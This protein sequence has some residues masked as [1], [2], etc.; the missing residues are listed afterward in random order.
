VNPE[1]SSINAGPPPPA[2]PTDDRRLGPL[3]EGPALTHQL[4]RFPAKLHPP[5]A[6]H[7]LDEFSEPGDRVLDPFCGS[8]TVLVEASVSGRHA[9]GVD[10][11]PLS[12][13]LSNVKVTRTEPSRLRAAG[14][15]LVE[16]LATLRRP[17]DEYLARRFEDI[18][19]DEL[20]R[21]LD[22]LWVP[23][24][25]NLRHWFR[26]YV[27]ADLA[28]IRRA[29]D[30]VGAGPDV[31]DV[32][33]TCFAASLRASSNADPV[34]VSGLEVTAHMRRRHAAGRVIDPFANFTKRLEA[35]IIAVE[36]YARVRDP[37]AFCAAI[38]GDATRMRRRM[39]GRFDAVITSPPYHAAVDY[40]RRHQLE[41]YWL[42]L[43]LS[44]DDRVRL[45]DRYLGRATVP[46]QHRLVRARGELPL[47]A[48]AIEREIRAAS[49]RRADAFIHYC[50]GLRR[51]YQA[52]A[53]QVEP[54]ARVVFVVGDSRWS[55][56]ELPAVAVMSALAQPALHLVDH[57]W[58]AARNRHMSF[59]RHNGADIDR[60]H[61]LVFKRVGRRQ[62]R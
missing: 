20:G 14:E 30:H 24:I 48:A 50:V 39:A 52:I 53:Q 10:V 3:P 43:T 5:L 18:S 35:A 33:A 47:E 28:V 56:G 9:T 31:R 55:D 62:A 45:L 8:G 16:T 7:L 40:Y 37:R 42:G 61:V 13:L 60:E 58:F 49:P 23:S 32:L 38:E 59:A 46:R 57:A 12:V 29:I 36:E 22:G 51:A 11:D 15:A 6:R 1:R 4:L 26:R 34:P 44:H 27:I 54:R 25:P 41:M 21:A 17:A 2:S 19:E